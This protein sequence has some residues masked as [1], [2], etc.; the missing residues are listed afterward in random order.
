MPYTDL[1]KKKAYEQ[2]RLKRIKERRATDPEYRERSR[3]SCKKWYDAKFAL[4]PEYREF[5]NKRTIVSRYGLSIEQYNHMLEQQSYKCLICNILHEDK[6]GKRLVIDHNHETDITDV[7]GLICN[8]CNLGLGI[9]KDNPEHLKA[10]AAYL[11]QCNEYQK[12]ST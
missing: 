1:E 7:R 12:L 11:E 2:R 10:A 8:A 4:N 6:K 5:R 3:L 9:F